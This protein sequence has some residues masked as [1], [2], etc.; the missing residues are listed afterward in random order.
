MKS[1]NELIEKSKTSNQRLGQFFCTEY[2]KEPWP[3]L[4]HTEDDNKAKRLIMTWLIDHNYTESL[5]I[6]LR[7]TL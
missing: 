7:R 4:Y 3:S 1:L 2:I 5:P 6:P